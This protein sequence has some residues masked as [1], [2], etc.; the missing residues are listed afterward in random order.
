MTMPKPVPV[1]PEA[2]DALLELN[3]RILWLSCTVLQNTD[4]DH[5]ETC[6]GVFHQALNCYD[7]ARLTLEANG[8]EIPAALALERETSH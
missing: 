4:A 8:V 2:A 6:E 1:P 5:C 3:R 7:D